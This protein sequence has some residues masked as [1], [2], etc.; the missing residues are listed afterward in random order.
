MPFGFLCPITKE[1]MEDPVIDC[2][3]HTFERQAIEQWFQSHNTSPVTNLP[4]ANKQLKPNY[5]LKTCIDLYLHPVDNAKVGT[6][7]AE[8]IVQKVKFDVVKQ[9]RPQD[10][11]L[12]RLVITRTHLGMTRLSSTPQCLVQIRVPDLADT[13]SS[14]NPLSICA[15]IDVSGSM[16]TTVKTNSKEETN[17]SA[18]SVV[19]HAVKT[20]VTILQ[21]EDQLSLVTYSTTAKEV[22]PM[23]LMDEVGRNT[24]IQTIQRIKTE[25]MTNLWA[26]I[27]TGLKTFD[28]AIHPNR[29]MIVLTDGQ[30]NDGTPSVG[31][32]LAFAQ[33]IRTMTNVPLTRFFGLGRDKIE[34]AD[35]NSMGAQTGG[36]FSY[37]SDASMIG[38]VFINTVV[39]MM[40]AMI[41]CVG[42][43]SDPR[44]DH[45]SIPT[46]TKVGPLIAGQTRHVITDATHDYLFT[47][48]GALPLPPATGDQ[49][50]EEVQQVI[51]EQIFRVTLANQLNRMATV[52]SQRLAILS[53]LQSDVQSI[54][55][56]FP[57]SAYLGAAQ[58]D[59]EGEIAMA[60]TESNYMTWGKHFLI[61]IGS[62]NLFEV[63][64]NFKDFSVRTFKTRLH[65]FLVS[66]VDAVFCLLPPPEPSPPTISRSTA[67]Y[68]GFAS[69]PAASM[70]AAAAPSLQLSVR[71]MSQYHDA[72]GGC[73]DPDCMVETL[74][75]GP[76]A[77]GQLKTGD[78]VI[79]QTRAGQKSS[80]QVTHVVFSKSPTNLYMRDSHSLYLTAW[81]PVLI[82]N[83]WQ[84]P[85][86]CPGF[87]P[88][89]PSA[90]HVCNVVLSQD[91]ILL[92]EGVPCITLGHG[93]QDD[94]V[95][96][97]PFFGT[98]RV[99][100][101]LNRLA[102]GN[103]DHI[104][105]QQ[106]YRDAKSNLITGFSDANSDSDIP[107]A[108]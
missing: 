4:V 90:K 89:T 1:C 65:Q 42:I 79:T 102:N 45:G 78:Q 101:H 5:A 92:V 108:L 26:G 28:K 36:G 74:N 67:S 35:M 41:P 104:F 61:S 19:L 91:H 23:T 9:H 72:D 96:A 100:D 2:N 38:T 56:R 43:T 13:G 21:P 105:I 106:I 59:L 94:P 51:A 44:V 22:L 80:A 34:S 31:Y 39:H 103:P 63:C 84:F 93:Y 55:D 98:Q 32:E 71:S 8:Q 30:S 77:I 16:Q 52:G 87:F 57:H 70:A 62:A 53:K 81:H 29:V 15:V 12:G 54:L 99:I 25:S 3:G 97:H 27:T 69:H 68:S 33:Q 66:I 47:P 37:I 18:L 50:E 64:N 24:A 82:N 73:F 14:R 95:L 86:E 58:K 7:T 46:V 17:L 88:V 76:I 83:K 60:T 75:R 107:I 48:F 85:A 40:S 49:K 10:L 20:L 11:D 6:A